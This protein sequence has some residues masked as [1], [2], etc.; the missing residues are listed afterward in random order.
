M[1]RCCMISDEIIPKNDMCEILVPSDV[2]G[3]YATVATVKSKF[4]GA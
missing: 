3:K 2:L 1:H 4:E